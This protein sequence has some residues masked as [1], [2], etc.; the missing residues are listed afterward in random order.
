MQFLAF[1]AGRGT[2]YRYSI[3][4]CTDTVASTFRHD[5]SIVQT[6]SASP[7][8]FSKLEVLRSNLLPHPLRIARRAVAI[9]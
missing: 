9:S 7:A 5:W 1:L 4:E 6:I 2:L 3:L 8:R